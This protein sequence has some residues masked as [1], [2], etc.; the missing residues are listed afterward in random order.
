MFYSRIQILWH[1][2]CFHSGSIYRVN[3]QHG[4]FSRKKKKRLVLNTSFYHIPYFYEVSYKSVLIY[5]WWD[6][7]QCQLQRPYHII[8]TV[9]LFSVFFYEFWDIFVLFYVFKDNCDTQRFTTLCIFI[10]S[11][12]VSLCLSLSLQYVLL[13]AL[14]DNCLT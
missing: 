10:L 14:G 7:C 9:S 2:K 4:F 11:L 6:Q 3:L 5:T 12:S 13:A 8:H 1:T